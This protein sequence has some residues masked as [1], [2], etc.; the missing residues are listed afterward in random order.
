MEGRILK[1]SETSGRSDD[2][3]EA[4]KKRFVTYSNETMPVIDEF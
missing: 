4:I 3:I 1:R 2:N